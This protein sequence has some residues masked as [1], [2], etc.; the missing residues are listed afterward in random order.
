MG[1]SQPERERAA[2][3]ASFNVLLDAHVINRDRGCAREY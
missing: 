1:K 2:H 3:G